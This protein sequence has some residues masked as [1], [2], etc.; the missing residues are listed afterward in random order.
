MDVLVSDTSVVVDLERARLIEALFTLP[1][2]VMV[3]DRLYDQEMRGHGGERLL[4][5]GLV[6]RSLTGDEVARAQRLRSRERRISL[7]DSYALSIAMTESAPLLSGDAALRRLAAAEHV[8]CHGVLWVFDQLE[9]HAAVTCS[10]LH[11]GLTVL[12]EHPRSR[13]PAREVDERLRRY[14]ASPGSVREDRGPWRVRA[15]FGTRRP[16]ARSHVRPK[17][18]VSGS[19]ALRL[20]Y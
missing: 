4:Q 19:P 5:L 16:A 8:R 18:G 11:A 17:L 10:R 6:V 12:A 1:H 2:Q 15:R 14:G 7:Y 9:V 3:P 13:L 20:H